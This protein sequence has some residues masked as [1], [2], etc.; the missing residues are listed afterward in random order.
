ML[1]FAVILNN[2]LPLGRGHKIDEF[3]GRSRA[4]SGAG[5]LT[6][7]MVGIHQQYVAFEPELSPREKNLALAAAMRR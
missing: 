3:G 6:E 7:R 4:W 2:F 5:R 1:I